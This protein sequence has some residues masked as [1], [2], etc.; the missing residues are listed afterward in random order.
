M[1]DACTSDW[2]ASRNATSPAL[3]LIILIGEAALGAG[4]LQEY[5][6]AGARGLPGRA[7]AQRRTDAAE[8]VHLA[9]RGRDCGGDIG[10]AA[11]QPGNGRIDLRD[12]AR[13]F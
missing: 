5:A 4:R 8:V 9:V 11:D 2:A 1:P 7:K 12:P 3:R 6:L 13:Q 10:A